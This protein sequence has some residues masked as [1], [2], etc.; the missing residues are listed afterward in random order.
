MIYGD[1]P[2]PTV[3]DNSVLIKVSKASINYI[4]TY[5]RTGL[6]KLPLP[7]ILGRDGAGVVEAVGSKVTEV[8]AGDRVAFVAPSAYAELVAA[9][10]AKVV[11]IPEN[12]DMSAACS[13]ASPPSTSCATRTA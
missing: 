8:A 9:P 5:H 12:I 2:A 4:D 11:K 10:E 1:R 7:T 13:R 3:G 6:Y